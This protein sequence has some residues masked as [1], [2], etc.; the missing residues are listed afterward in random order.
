[1]ANKA[2]ILNV[3]SQQKRLLQ[4]WNARLKSSYSGTRKEVVLWIALAIL[5]GLCGGGD[6]VWSRLQ[7]FPH[8]SSW[9]IAWR[10]EETLQLQLR[11]SCVRVA[12]RLTAQACREGRVSISEHRICFLCSQVFG[13][14]VVWGFWWLFCS[15]VTTALEL[16]GLCA[17]PFYCVRS[18]CPLPWGSSPWMGPQPLLKCK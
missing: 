2:K 7:H 3:V 10:A 1:M 13:V 5:T 9:E 6:R 11:L 16:K 8:V 18:Q 15:S 14:W 17:W 4:L 12:A